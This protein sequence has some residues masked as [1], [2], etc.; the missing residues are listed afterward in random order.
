MSETAARFGDIRDALDLTGKVAIVTGA[1]A[2]LGVAMARALGQA[3]A[4]VALAGRREAELKATAEIVRAAGA[5][6]LPVPTDVTDPVACRDLVQQTVRAFG[7]LDI[8]VNNAGVAAAVPALRESRE[9]FRR[10]VALNLEACFW[11]AQ[12]AA[13]AMEEGASIINISSALAL[14]TAGLPQ[15]A[16]SASK[17]GVLGLTRDLAQQWSPRR[18]IR[19]NAICPGLF[20]SDMTKQYPE[21]YT[22]Q[23][24]ERRSLVRRAG[25]PDELAATVVFLAGAG[26][27]YITGATLVVDGGMSI[28]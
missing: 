19:V 4:D 20:A 14:T 21:G 27:G 12:E 18:G 10:V 22:D 6:A 15:A 8:L 5:R 1:S 24:I 26:A 3:G 11:M 9:E 28:T 23:L 13:R 17:A 25:H 16:Y 7:R 2:G